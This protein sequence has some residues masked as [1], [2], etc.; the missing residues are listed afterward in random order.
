M[1]LAA[2]VNADFLQPPALLLKF[3]ERIFK[4]STVVRFHL[5]FAIRLQNVCIARNEGMIGQAL[6]MGAL[7]RPGIGKIQMD[8]IDLS[9][10]KPGVDHLGISLNIQHVVRQLGILAY[11]QG[12]HIDVFFNADPCNIRILLCHLHPVIP[13]AGPDFHMQLCSLQ[14]LLPGSG[15]CRRI[16]NH[17]LLLFQKILGPGQFSHSHIRLLL[18]LF[19]KL[20]YGSGIDGNRS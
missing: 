11:S 9:L 3:H 16:G 12:S 1:L 4:Q 2:I 17:N 19:R 6:F 10:C 18:I 5:N 15:K 7:F 14:G 20:L 8:H 13:F